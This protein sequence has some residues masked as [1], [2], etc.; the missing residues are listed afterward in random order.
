M[1]AKLLRLASVRMSAAMLAVALAERP[2][3]G[4]RAASRARARRNAETQ[5]PGTF[6]P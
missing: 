6:S 5:R 1:R 3:R 4:A 2:G